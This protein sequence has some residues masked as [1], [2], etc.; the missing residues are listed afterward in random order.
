MNKN[1]FARENRA[2][3]ERILGRLFFEELLLL[4]LSEQERIPATRGIGRS[5]LEGQTLGKIVSERVIRE[6]LDTLTSY[7]HRP[8]VIETTLGVGVIFGSLMPATSMAVL[9]LPRADSQ[10]VVTFLRRQRMLYEQLRT[11]DGIYLRFAPLR[12]DWS[13]LGLKDGLDFSWEQ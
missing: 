11:E 5:S 10:T 4:D 2:V 13:L 8:I 3:E 9:W 7:E 12:R 1:R 6:L